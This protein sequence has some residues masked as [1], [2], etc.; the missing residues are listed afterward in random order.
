M[1]KFNGPNKKRID[2]RYFLNEKMEE[3]EEVVMDPAGQAAA[4]AQRGMRQAAGVEDMPPWEQRP[5]TDYKNAHSNQEARMHRT[6]LLEIHKDAE[7]LLQMI[8]DTDDLPEWCEGK[9]TEA[10]ASLESVLEYITGNKARE[11]GEL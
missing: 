3:V 1:P 8:Q 5:T 9:I 7:A 6:N 10:A 11:K 4:L 2:P